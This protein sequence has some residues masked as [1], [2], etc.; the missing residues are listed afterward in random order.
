[1]RGEMVGRLYLSRQNSDFFPFHEELIEKL[2]G[3]LGL[4]S[5]DAFV[6][7][8]SL[9]TADLRGVYSHGC[10]RVPVYYER[11]LKGG[12]SVNAKPEIIRGR[13]CNGACGWP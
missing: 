11:F 7:A 13:P 5:T 8:D 9:V 3:C 4:D 12:T 6:C 10:V 2:F 1:M